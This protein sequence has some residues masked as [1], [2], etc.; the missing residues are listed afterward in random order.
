LVSPFLGTLLDPPF[1]RFVHGSQVLEGIKGIAGLLQA[2][3]LP[4]MLLPG[5]F[6]LPR[7][8]ML[9]GWQ[10]SAPDRGV[11]KESLAQKYWIKGVVTQLLSLLQAMPFFGELASQKRFCPQSIEFVQAPPTL[12]AV[13]LAVG[14]AVGRA[15]G[16]AV[17]ARAVG[18]VVGAI[19][20]F[21]DRQ[22]ALLSHVL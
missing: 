13:G 5:L 14:L 4:S 6:W 16:G 3:Q 21:F 1:T 9:Q 15:V 7:L 19:R 22:S 2:P 20:Q 18:A 12:M 10:V 8:H 17:G 11:V